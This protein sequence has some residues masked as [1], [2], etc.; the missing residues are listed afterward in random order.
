MKLTAFPVTIVVENKFGH[1][2][3]EHRCTDL[4]ML[5][6]TYSKLKSLYVINS[7]WNIFFVCNSKVNDMIPK[8]MI[9]SDYEVL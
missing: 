9:E 2:V 3:H 5:Q 4:G 8:V 1:I 6:R 7:E